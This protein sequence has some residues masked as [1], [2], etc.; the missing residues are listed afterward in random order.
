MSWLGTSL[1]LVG[2]VV[3]FTQ[4]FYP[5]FMII[6]MLFRESRILYPF[7]H[8]VDTT[9]K[10]HGGELVAQVIKSHGVENIFT[11]PGNCESPIV[12]AAEELDIK[13][14]DVRD[15]AKAEFATTTSAQIPGIPSVVVVTA[16]Q[17][18]T[19]IVT[20]IKNAQIDESPLVI[21]AE[22]PTTTL[23][24]RGSL[25]DVNQMSSIKS[26]T[27]KCFT[28]DCVR[29]IVPTLREAFRLSQ[30]DVPG[31]VF[32]ELPVDILH[33]YKVISEAISSNYLLNHIFADAWKHQDF[34]PL[35]V[36]LKPSKFSRLTSGS[37]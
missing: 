2:L 7:F 37:I 14:I 25:Q 30:V 33:P 6:A 27:K 23:K 18:S 3:C 15:K 4:S 17:D 1:Y 8:Q 13:V 19:N 16:G 10:K 20:A 36:T 22:A 26:T 34:D 31:P 29:D 32:V 35:P 11:L 24:N 9:S 12:S 5:L 28:A 21:V